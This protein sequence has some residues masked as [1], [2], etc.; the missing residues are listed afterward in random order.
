MGEDGDHDA[1]IASFEK[2]ELKGA[3]EITEGL[4]RRARNRWLMG[5]VIEHEWVREAI[6]VDGGLRFREEE[7]GQE[8][9]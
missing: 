9:L 3:M 7:E 5:Q 4:L 1:N 2:D 6:Q 8:V